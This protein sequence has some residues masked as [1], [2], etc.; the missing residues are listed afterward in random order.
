MNGEREMIPLESNQYK[1]D[2]VINQHIMRMINT[3]IYWFGQTFRAILMEL[4]K[5][6]NG[7]TIAQSSEELSNEDTHHCNESHATFK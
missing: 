5:I 6:R 4:Q 1:N 7:E 2:L 3:K